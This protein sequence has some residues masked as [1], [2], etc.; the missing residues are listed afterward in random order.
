[1]GVALNTYRSQ[2][3]DNFHNVANKM[4]GPG[5]SGETIHQANPGIAGGPSDPI[6]PGHMLNIPSA[7]PVG[8]APSGEA[9]NG[10]GAG[11]WKGST[12]ARNMSASLHTNPIGDQGKDDEKRPRP[13]TAGH[14]RVKAGK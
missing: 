10:V 2:H 13:G 11:S 5:Q 1:M 6:E 4:W 3:G 7:P 9:G 8:T 12:R 14:K